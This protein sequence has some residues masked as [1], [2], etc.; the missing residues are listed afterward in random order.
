MPRTTTPPGRLPPPFEVGTSSSLAKQ[1][2][3][4][5]GSATRIRV[6]A[7]N[8]RNLLRERGLGLAQHFDL[9]FSAL[10]ATA[11]ARNQAYDDLDYLYLQFTFP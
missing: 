10:R 7:E 3:H 4:N 9:D 2:V 1:S 8:G 6:D 5:F 11:E